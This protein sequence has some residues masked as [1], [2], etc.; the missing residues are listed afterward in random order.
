MARTSIRS[1]GALRTAT[2]CSVLLCSSLFAA[3]QM[4]FAAPSMPSTGTMKS[5]SE[6]LRECMTQQ[7]EG[8]TACFQS[9]SSDERCAGT[10]LAKL[11][12]MRWTASPGTPGEGSLALLGPQ[13]IDKECIENFDNQLSADLIRGVLS[14]DETYA[15]IARLEGCR[16]DG[17]EEMYRP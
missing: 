13:F 12:F 10:E 17:A 15:L 3:P 6:L 9:T 2:A 8:R 1:I 7:D 16:K 14:R 5:C 4:S 11:A